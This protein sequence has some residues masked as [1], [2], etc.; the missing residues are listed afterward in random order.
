MD[1]CSRFPWGH[2]A[3]LAEPEDRPGVLSSS[4]VSTV[5]SPEPLGSFCD[6]PPAPARV[7]VPALPCSGPLAVTLQ[8]LQRPLQGSESEPAKSSGWTDHEALTSCAPALTS[9]NLK[10]TL[11]A[12]S[13][14]ISLSFH[15]HRIA[16]TLR[17]GTR[18]YAEVQLGSSHIYGAVEG[19]RRLAATASS[20]SPIAI[21][22][23][24]TPAIMSEV[25]EQHL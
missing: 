21:P 3:P 14:Q 24:H 6:A 7:W 5:S 4:F 17:L 19:I 9:L 1:A 2:S 8:Q 22:P 12:L 13:R 20:S 16:Q 11:A 23:T 15:R 10:L 25:A 18:L